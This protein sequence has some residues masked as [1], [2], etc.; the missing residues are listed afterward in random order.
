MRQI[1]DAPAFANFP[2]RKDTDQLHYEEGRFIGYRCFDRPGAPEPMYREF[3]CYEM[4][5][6][7][8]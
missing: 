8:G 7:R 5:L 6:C 1:E 4:D 2:A 3:W